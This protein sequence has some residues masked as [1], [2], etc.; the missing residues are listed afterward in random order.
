MVVKEITNRIRRYYFCDGDN[1]RQLDKRLAWVIVELDLG[2]GM[3][4]D[5]VVNWG[6]FSVKLIID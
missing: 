6:N 5:L 1:L 2:G 3:L 4:E